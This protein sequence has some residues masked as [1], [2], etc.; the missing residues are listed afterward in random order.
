MSQRSN[1]Q[2][3]QPTHSAVQAQEDDAAVDVEPVVPAQENDE[4]ADANAVV[5][6]QENSDPS[7]AGNAPGASNDQQHPLRERPATEHVIQGGPAMPRFRVRVLTS[8]EIDNLQGRVWDLEN[9]ILRREER[10]RVCDARFPY[11]NPQEVG[12]PLPLRHK[13]GF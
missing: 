6:A 1:R 9:Q 10:C 11:D 13:I 4:A 5:Q 8:D 2:N 12:W 3:K 7:N